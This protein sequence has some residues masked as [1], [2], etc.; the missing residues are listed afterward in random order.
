MHSQTIQS[1]EELHAYVSGMSI[2]M[3]SIFRG[4]RDCN[5]ELIPSIGRHI[6]EQRATLQAAERRIFRLFC[7]AA[8]PHLTFTPRNAWEWLAVAQHHGLPTRLLDWTTNPL[9]AAYFAVEAEHHADSAIYVFSGSDTIN[10]DQHPDPFSITE[11]IRYRPPHISARVVAQSGVF[12][13]HPRP[14]EPFASP[15]IQKLIISQ[16]SRGT[17]KKPNTGWAAERCS[18]DLMVLLRIW[19]GCSS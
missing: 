12:T 18:L 10:P 14:A 8:L 6:P 11:V 2:G 1:F 3:S 7:E 13:V 15:K 9:V 4:V 17:I 19:A 5:H 16:D